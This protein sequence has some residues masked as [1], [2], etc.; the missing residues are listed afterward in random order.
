MHANGRDLRAAS[1]AQARTKASK[2][3][4][5]VYGVIDKNEKFLNCQ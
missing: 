4:F 2:R 3:V 5:F 1:H